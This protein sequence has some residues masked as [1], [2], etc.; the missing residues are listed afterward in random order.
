MRILAESKL[1]EME[2]TKWRC[3]QWSLIEEKKLIS[4]C[5]GNQEIRPRELKISDLVLKKVL[6]ISAN[7]WGKIVPK[8]RSTTLIRKE[9]GKPKDRQGE[10]SQSSH[11]RLYHSEYD[12]TQVVEASNRLKIKIKKSVTRNLNFRA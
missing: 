7:F 6:H 3:E 9:I 11:S 4:C 12:A 5:Q 10:P 8:Q 2:W 1:E